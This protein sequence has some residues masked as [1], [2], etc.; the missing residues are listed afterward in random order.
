MHPP[1]LYPVHRVVEV[2][3]D[4]LVS[5]CTGGVVGLGF[6]D[7]VSKEVLQRGHEGGLGAPGR[8]RVGRSGSRG[9]TEEEEEDGEGEKREGCEEED[10]GPGSWA[11][12]SC[13]FSVFARE[14]DSSHVYIITIW[15][16]FSP[17]AVGHRPFT[18]E[19][20]HWRQGRNFVPTVGGR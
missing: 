2:S 17:C 19:V 14:F 20:E 18:S 1:A 6:G 10:W 9:E 12:F 15:F 16:S 5:R 8:V 13:H 7:S 3:D 11:V 4:D